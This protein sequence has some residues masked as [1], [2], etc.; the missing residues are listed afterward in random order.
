MVDSKFTLLQTNFQLDWS[1]LQ[2][3]EL[4]VEVSK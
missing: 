2:N 3:F 4:V 1:E